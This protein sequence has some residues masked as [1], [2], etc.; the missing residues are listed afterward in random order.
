MCSAHV[1]RP[2]RWRWRRGDG[3]ERGRGHGEREKRGD[4]AGDDVAARAV[5]IRGGGGGRMQARDPREPRSFQARFGSNSWLWGFLVSSPVHSHVLPVPFFFRF[6]PLRLSTMRAHPR[7]ADATGCE[8]IAQVPGDMPS[9]ALTPPEI[10]RTTLAPAY[11]YPRTL[12]GE[13]SANDSGF[14]QSQP[15]AKRR[16]ANQGPWVNELCA[17]HPPTCTRTCTVCILSLTVRES[18]LKFGMSNIHRRWHGRNSI[19]SREEDHLHDRS[20]S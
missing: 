19:M 1:A 20:A 18:P 4:A 6:F 14:P 17:S 11:G 13:L 15:Q 3:D 16:S 2:G 8:C 9:Y 5:L 7:P 12:Y 10:S